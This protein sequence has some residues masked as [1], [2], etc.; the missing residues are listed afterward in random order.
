ME[1]EFKFNLQDASVFD[2]IVENAEIN[3]MGLEAVE[4]IDMHAAY[5][6]TLE[7]DLRSPW[8]R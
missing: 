1:T 4:T 5:F 8:C 7:Q 3:R 2:H 6:D